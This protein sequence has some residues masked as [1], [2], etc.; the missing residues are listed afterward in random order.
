MLLEFFFCYPVT[1]QAP[2]FDQTLLFG[3]TPPFDQTPMFDQTL[4]FDQTPLFDQ[5]PILGQPR[6]STNPGEI[7]ICCS[8]FFLLPRYNTGPAVRPNPKVYSTTIT[9]QGFTPPYI[10]IQ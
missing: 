2:M 1:T 4:M 5:T 6:C 7:P 10:Y 3:Q 9:I 8:S